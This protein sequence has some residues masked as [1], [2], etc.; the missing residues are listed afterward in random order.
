MPLAKITPAEARSL[1]DRGALLVDV[2]E[3]SER[4]REWID[5]SVSL[6]LSQLAHT[7]V[8][9]DAEVVVY[10]CRSG[11]RTSANAAALAAKV[12]CPAYILDGGMHAW[13]SAGLP[14]ATGV[15]TTSGVQAFSRFALP[16]LVLLGGLVALYVLRG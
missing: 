9:K 15:G 7:E 16:A 14:V 11:M 4:A 10:L 3:P 1:V 2:R 5:G 6:P 13:Q 12:G 8:P